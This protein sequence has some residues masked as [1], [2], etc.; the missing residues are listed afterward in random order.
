MYTQIVVTVL[1]VVWNII[2]IEE[3][4]LG[5]SG[6]GLSS[7]LSNLIALIANIY[8]THSREEIA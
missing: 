4:G 3:L 2:F 7:L 1:H 8:M 5:I 6:I